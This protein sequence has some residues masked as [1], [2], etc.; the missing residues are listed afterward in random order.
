MSGCLL[1]WLEII[2]WPSVINIFKSRNWSV[3]DDKFLGNRLS[4]GVKIICSR[5]IYKQTRGR[6][7]KWDEV[8]NGCTS[9]IQFEVICF[10]RVKTEILQCECRINIWPWDQLTW[11]EII[12]FSRSFHKIRGSRI[13]YGWKKYGQ[14]LQFSTNFILLRIYWLFI[15][16]CWLSGLASQG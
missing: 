16:F 8:V 9:V 1:S 14:N 13:N 15:S 6:I 12:M 2:Y 4:T 11:Y 3:L 5:L 10:I 7:N